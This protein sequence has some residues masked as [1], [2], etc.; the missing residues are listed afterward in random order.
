MMNRYLIAAALILG[1][2][3]GG[4]STKPVVVNPPVE[5]PIFTTQALVTGDVQSPVVVDDPLQG[6]NR[7]M[8]RFNYHADKWVLNPAVKTYRFIVPSPLRTGVK[9][10]FNNFF[11]IRTFWNQ[12]LQGRPVRALATSGRFALNT[13]VGIGGLFDV[14]TKAGMPYYKEDFGQTLGV[15]GFGP[16]AYLVLPLFGPSSVRDAIGLGVD[17]AIMSAI[18]PLGLDGHP[19]RQY[20]YY[21]LLIINT[22]AQVGFQYY[23]TGSPFEYE[24]VRRLM[25]TVRQIEVQK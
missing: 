20:V 5:E 16:G 9:N 2:G 23:S 18:D 14:A 19:Q 25:L 13:T 17:G 10:F 3:V 8:Y 6:F 7:T 21:P 1:L 15:W 22:R 12:L 4:C 11:G 24:L